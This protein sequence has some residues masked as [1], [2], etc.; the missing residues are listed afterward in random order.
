MNRCLLAIAVLAAPGIPAMCDP[1]PPPVVIFSRPLP[2]ANV[3]EPAQ[4]N[5][6]NFAITDQP[7]SPPNDPL[8]FLN[9]DGDDFTLNAQANNAYVIQSLTMWSVGSTLGEAIGNEF[10]NIS[11]YMR[12]V[13]VDPVTGAQT[14]LAPFT[15]VSTGTPN[16]NFN[17]DGVTV[18]DSNSNITHTNVQYSNGQDYEGVGTPG[19]Y[20]PLWQNTFNNLNLTLLAGTYEF[21]VWGIGW[22][23]LCTDVDFQCMDYQS[24]YG[25]FYP[26]YSNA[27]R[28]GPPGSQ[29][30]AD[31]YFL[32]YDAQ[33]LSAQAAFINAA[34][35]GI[36]PYGVDENVILSGTGV[37]EPA[38]FG[39]A[40]LGLIG[41]GYF[42]RR[43]RKS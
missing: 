42:S 40:G 31:G 28:S 6:S 38:T 27:L 30:G 33:N 18:G 43:L 3:N 4:P 24:T 2:T 7:I 13:S 11:L 17:G 39:L 23:N 29:Q 41:L 19:T 37:P 10:Q 32:K 8:A 12:Q 1:L 22:Q 15:I 21:A 36:T 35:L 16:T 26:E 20:Y 25:Y 14:P 9:F 5:R 34:Q